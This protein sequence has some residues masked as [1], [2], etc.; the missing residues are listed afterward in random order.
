MSWD[1]GYPTNDYDLELSG[2]PVAEAFAALSWSERMDKLEEMCE[3]MGVDM[4]EWLKQLAKK[5][6]T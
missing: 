3:R 1:D 2:D 6:V 5:R 4:M